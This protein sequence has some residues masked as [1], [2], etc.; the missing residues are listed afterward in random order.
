MEIFS[1]GVSSHD[2]PLK[3]IHAYCNLLCLTA[4]ASQGE[5][6]IIGACEHYTVIGCRPYTGAG[7]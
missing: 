7:L 2:L 3:D 5:W 4:L 6:G 1:S